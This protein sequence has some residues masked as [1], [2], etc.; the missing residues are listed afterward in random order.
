MKG[1]AGWTMLAT[2]L[3]WCAVAG[4]TAEA[5]AQ[6]KIIIRVATYYAASHPVQQ[7]LEFFKRNLEE[8]SGGRF[9]VQVYPN[10][11]LGSEEVYTDLIKRGTIQ[12]GVCGLL[13]KK[14]EAK[15]ALAAPPLVIQT[16]KQ[17]EACFN[18]PIGRK[19]IGDY[20][21]NTDIHIVGYMVN[22]FRN[23]SSSYAIDAMPE[24]Q[25]LTIR[26]PEIEVFAR[27]LKGFGCD[28]VMMPRSEVYNALETRAAAGQENSLSVLRASGWHEVQGHVLMSRHMFACSPVIV[29]GRF[30]G[31]I[32]ASLRPV[33]DSNIRKAI[34]HNWMISREDE[35]A[36]IAFLKEKGLSIVEPSP[37]FR[38]AMRDALEDFFAWYYKEIPGA[39]EI[40]AE[41]DALPK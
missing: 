17:A 21:R 13:I 30:L 32:P 35:E 22:G 31:S 3:A 2:C 4:M 16:W 29:N 10:N 24:L 40:I 15:T 25:R 20:T 1:I 26:V 34:A 8:E 38:H 5:R 18:G 33:F 41:M 37:E 11:Q 19:I 9:A 23:I 14:D 39:Q 27:L 12:M 36:S 7:S 28:A 6:E